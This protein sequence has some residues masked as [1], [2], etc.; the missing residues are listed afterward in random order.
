MTRA[1]DDVRDQTPAAQIRP[2]EEVTD[3]GPADDTAHRTRR[4]RVDGWRLIMMT[5]AAVICVIAGTKTATP[6]PVSTHS[7][8]VPATIA[9]AD[10]G[11]DPS[12]AGQPPP[13]PPDFSPQ[14][15]HATVSRFATNFASANG[16]RDGWLSRI[17]GDVVPELLDQYALTDIRNLPRST[18]QVMSAVRTDT[19][20]STYQVFRVAYSDSSELDIVVEMTAEG[21]KI[22]TVEPVR[23]SAPGVVDG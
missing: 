13:S 4:Q 9:G 17:S 3:A 15:A 11:P 18:L 19:V 5:A 16:D 10:Q 6:P 23:G 22:G 2:G 7:P 21:W 14:A 20:P 12:G 1:D 8:T